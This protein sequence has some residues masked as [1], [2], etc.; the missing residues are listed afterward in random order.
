MKNTLTK[1]QLLF[2]TVITLLLIVFAASQKEATA[3]FIWKTFHTPRIAL[4]IH[5]DAEFSFEI[6]NY[7]FNA[8]GS[9]VYDQEKAKKYFTK[10]L[11]L[12]SGHMFARHQLARI[13]FL[14]GDFEEA[15]GIINTQIELHG[16]LV[17]SSYYVR[18]LIY[19]FVGSLNEA[20]RDFL[21]FISVKDNNW[22]G[23]NDIAWVYFQKG[24]YARALEY[25]SKGLLLAPESPWL[26]TTKGVVLMNLGENTEAISHLE[27]ALKLTLELEPHSWSQTN[28]GNDP[29]I[30]KEGLSRMEEIIRE[31]LRLASGE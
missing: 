18:G 6:G 28:P 9:G 22:G 23:Y 17:V 26:L 13:S 16:D 8:E 5:N 15:I 30:A 27:K 4:I 10:T 25:A 24:D 2:L 7:Y 14:R 3:S 29:R 31:N 19:G 12:D 1:P 11:D 21:H 20:E